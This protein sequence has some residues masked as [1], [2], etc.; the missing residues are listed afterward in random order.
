MAL[1][2]NLRSGLRPLIGKSYILLQICSD[3]DIYCSKVWKANLALD[4]VIG[5]TTNVGEP[6]I[7]WNCNST[8]S[9]TIVVE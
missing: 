1:K 6:V 3:A 2:F 4:C 9:V 7:F 8:E 5:E